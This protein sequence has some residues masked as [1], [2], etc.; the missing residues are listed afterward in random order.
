MDL[1]V[2]LLAALV[3]ALVHG[4]HGGRE[5]EADGLVDV[6]LGGDGGQA[7]LGERFG[8]ADDGFELADGDGDGGARVGLE[9]GGVH[10]LADGDEVGGEFLG[11]FSGKVRC[12]SPE[13][14]L[15]VI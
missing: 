2:Q 11:G 10:L 1:L 9:F 4:V 3:G 5:E 15:V 7:D 12:T 6:G 13:I 8:D 14:L